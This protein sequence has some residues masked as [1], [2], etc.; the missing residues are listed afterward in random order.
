LTAH[1]DTLAERMGVNVVLVCRSGARAGKACEALQRTG[2][3]GVDVLDGGIAAYQDAVGGVTRRG[4][5][6]AMDRH[7]RMAAGTLVLAGTL[8]GHLVY[9]RLGLFA[10]AFGAGLAYSALSYT[11]AMAAALSRMSWNRAADS[12]TV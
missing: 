11:C 9:R 12:P 7:V 8:G 4:G 10:A 2:L 5:R 1:S 3:E 6:W